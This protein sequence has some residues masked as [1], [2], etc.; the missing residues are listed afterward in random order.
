MREEWIYPLLCGTEAGDRDAALLL[1][2]RLN[3]AIKVCLE[4]DIIVIN[5]S[6]DYFKTVRVA[7]SF[8]DV[9]VETEIPGEEPFIT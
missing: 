4:S 8:S 7:S 9:R 5:F 6:V 2:S 3:G 1:Y